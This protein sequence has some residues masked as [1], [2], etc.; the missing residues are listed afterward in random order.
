MLFLFCVQKAM[1][2]SLE[3][4]RVLQMRLDDDDDTYMKRLQDI[5]AGEWSCIIEIV[6][7][8]IMVHEC[9]N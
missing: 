1:I 3:E 4:T 7:Y 6:A 2:S 5:N 9:R 8:R